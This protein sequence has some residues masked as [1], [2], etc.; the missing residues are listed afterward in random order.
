MQ[1]KHGLDSNLLVLITGVAPVDNIPKTTIKGSLDLGR[2]R[3]PG[4]TPPSGEMA[5]EEDVHHD[6]A[7]SKG[8][9]LKDMT[10]F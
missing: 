10:S 2:T 9:L 6:G 4:F 1:L 8:D 5:T 7:N 3:S